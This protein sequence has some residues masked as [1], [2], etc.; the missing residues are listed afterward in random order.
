MALPPHTP[1][2]QELRPPPTSPPGCPPWQQQIRS[3]DTHHHLHLHFFF[4][5]ERAL[6][7]SSLCSSLPLR[8]GLAQADSGWLAMRSGHRPP[9]AE[10]REPQDLQGGEPA[11]VCCLQCRQC[12]GGL[13]LVLPWAIIGIP[14]AVVHLATCGRVPALRWH[15][16]VEVYCGTGCVP[17]DARGGRGH[18][19][20]GVVSSRR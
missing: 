20:G 12:C 8:L 3:R 17:K 16:S 11:H 9:D 18:P 6:L 4:D 1:A 7:L 2:R 19:K 13:F 5:C 15:R 10:R 14:L